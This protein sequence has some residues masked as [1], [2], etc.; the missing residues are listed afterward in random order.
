MKYSR[1][2]G[3]DLHN[4][5]FLL[6]QD[7]RRRE[8]SFIGR[9]EVHEV[10][11]KAQAGDRDAIERAVVSV[12]LW[13]L[14]RAMRKA[15]GDYHDTADL[16]QDTCVAMM[17]AIR[18]WDGQYEGTWFNHVNRRVRCCLLRA[19]RPTQ[20]LFENELYQ[21]SR[22]LDPFTRKPCDYTEGQ[23]V[24]AVE[25]P[26][27]RD[28]VLEAITHLPHWHQQ[29][30]SMSMAGYTLD[31]IAGALGCTKQNVCKQR[32]KAIHEIQKILGEQDANN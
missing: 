11:T 22:V 7:I 18:T 23:Q 16:F 5:L 12:C 9:D 26:L 21:L 14:K 25:Q 1:A 32:Q 19:P 2:N 8:T 3:N 30:L 24:N 10:L 31:D 13:A 6:C 27:D 20:R 4:V 15:R 29:V 17:D 28:D